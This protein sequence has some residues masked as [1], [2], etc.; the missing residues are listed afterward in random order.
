METY[1]FN[2]E[3]LSAHGINQFEA[4]EDFCNRLEKNK[5]GDAEILSK[6][7]ENQ[8]DYIQD[9]NESPEWAELN[10][11]SQLGKIYEAVKKFCHNTEIGRYWS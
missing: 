1:N 6:F 8:L 3:G 10:E 5:V 4:M 11:E 7:D 2:T 9:L